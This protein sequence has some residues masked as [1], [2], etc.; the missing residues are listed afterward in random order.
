MLPGPKGLNESIFLFYS[1][2][3]KCEIQF[4]KT[5]N[6]PIDYN[7]GPRSVAIGDFNNDTWLDIVVANH[8]VN[9]I[10]IFFGNINGTFSKQPPYS[11][12]S[13]SAPN[14]VAVGDFN[15]DSRLEYCSCELWH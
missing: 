7:F 5:A 4:E 10:I 6:N 13:N 2:V 9:S 14:M 11:T 15:N 12:G 3:Q 1:I 8:I